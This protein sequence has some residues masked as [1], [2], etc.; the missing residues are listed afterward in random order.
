M[1]YIKLHYWNWDLSFT[2]FLSCYTTTTTTTYS[3][4]W[5]L[6]SWSKCCQRPLCWAFTRHFLQPSFLVFSSTPSIHLDFSQPCRHW[7][8]GF[9]HS[10]FLG[11]S[12]SSIRTW[13]AH[14]V[15]L[16]FITLAIFGSL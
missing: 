10:I 9:V 6:A 1:E 14:L 11:N 12:F 15:L 5:A 4:G 3:P 13:P 2:M 7:P 16:D 8:P